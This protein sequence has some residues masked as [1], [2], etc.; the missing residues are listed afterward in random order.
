MVEDITM[1]RGRRKVDMRLLLPTTVK[2][3]LEL[4]EEDREDTGDSF[5]DHGPPGLEKGLEVRLRQ[6]KIPSLPR[7]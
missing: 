6:D 1:S 5:M 7:Q 4:M 3:G 2:A